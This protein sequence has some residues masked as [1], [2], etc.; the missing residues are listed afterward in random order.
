M[1]RALGER[2]MSSQYLNEPRLHPHLHHRPTVNQN[3]YGPVIP[4]SSLSPSTSAS[5]CP[6][7]P[8]AL[9]YFMALFF[10]LYRVLGNHCY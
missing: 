5:T 7:L 9:Y 3:A 6:L 8:F 4:S 2:E 10:D 1:G